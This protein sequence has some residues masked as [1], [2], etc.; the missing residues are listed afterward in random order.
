MNAEANGSRVAVIE[1][2]VRVREGATDTELHPGEQVSTS[3]KLEARPVTQQI[4]WSRQA[5]AHRA[6][7]AAF[8]KGMADTAG[9]LRPLANTSVPPRRRPA[10]P[11]PLKLG[12]PGRNSKRRQ[13]G[14]AIRTISRRRRRAAEGAV[15]TAST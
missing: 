13:S 11:P 3:P 6:I 8:A 2:E 15:P 7:L 4:A 14:C 1:G 10:R 9:S 12:R 5:D